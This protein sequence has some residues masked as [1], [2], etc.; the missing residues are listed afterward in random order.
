MAAGRPNRVPLV[1]PHQK[2]FEAFVITPANNEVQLGIMGHSRAT[3]KDLAEMKVSHPVLFRN[4][5]LPKTWDSLTTVFWACYHENDE[6]Y[7]DNIYVHCPMHV[8]LEGIVPM[9]IDIPTAYPA[10]WVRLDGETPEGTLR[11]LAVE[12]LQNGDNTMTP[13]GE[14]VY[15]SLVTFRNEL[16]IPD[17]PDTRN[18]L[19]VALDGFFRQGGELRPANENPAQFFTALTAAVSGDP[20]KFAAKM[21]LEHAVVATIALCKQGV[22][23]DTKLTKIL[24]AAAN[25]NGIDLN[26]TLNDIKD[27]YQHMEYYIKKHAVPIDNILGIL[28][29][30]FP[31][32]AFMRINLTI[33]QTLGSRASA[34]NIILQAIRAYQKSPLW[35][36]LSSTCPQEWDD[37]WAAARVLANDQL[38]GFKSRDYTE[39]IKG[40]KFPS[41]LYGAKGLLVRVAKVKTLGKYKATIQTLHAAKIDACITAILDAI[42]M[43][44]DLDALQ[45][46]ANPLI[47]AKAADL[48]HIFG[49]LNL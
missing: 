7:T 45:L 22:I 19:M 5:G 33:V 16:G 21:A 49:S 4:S 23:T 24:T 37:F 48:A 27:L 46:A 8:F 30:L 38:A 28:Y 13:K 12:Q 39:E 32:D 42:D 29:N 15:K 41:I 14:L 20:T 40:T 1:G 10:G 43:E 36:L 3:I 11:R 9:A 17:A 31:F 34:V 6:I 25:E 44:I 26:C 18:P 35:A 2:F 47:D